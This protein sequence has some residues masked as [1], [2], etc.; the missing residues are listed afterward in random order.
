MPK[1]DDSGI[2]SY[3]KEKEGKAKHPNKER[4]IC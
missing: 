4:G 3:D 1:R 2:E